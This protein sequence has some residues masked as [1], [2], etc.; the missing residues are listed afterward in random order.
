MI[1][2]YNEIK[3]KNKTLLNS[4][5]IGVE[6]T[7]VYIIRGKN[8]TGKSLLINYLY[9]KLIIRKEKAVFID[10]TND[11]ILENEGVLQNIALIDNVDELKKIESKLQELNMSYL[12]EHTSKELS[13]GEK[14]LICLLRGLLAEADYYFIDEPTNDLDYEITSKIADLIDEIGKKALVLLVTHDDRMDNY[15]NGIYTIK[16]KHLVNENN[17]VST[18]K[19]IIND[20]KEDSNQR[21]S[22]IKER[23]LLKQFSFKYIT[24]LLCIICLLAALDSGISIRDAYEQQIDMMK[25]RQIDIFIP[26]SKFGNEIIEGALPIAYASF[27]RGDAS[28]SEFTNEMRKFYNRSEQEQINFT[29]DLEST[30]N[31][32][33]YKLEY[34]DVF[35]QESFLVLEDYLR[36][37][38]KSPEDIFVDT[39]QYFEQV[40]IENREGL[41]KVDFNIEKFEENALYYENNMT[42]SSKPY[43]LIFCSVIL[44]EGYSINKF[45]D[46]SNFK[47]LKNG[48]FYIRSNETISI[49]NAAKILESKKESIIYFFVT[50]FVCL[51]IELI[52]LFLYLK[53]NRLKI[54]IFRNMSYLPCKIS[55]NVISKMKDGTIR[56]VFCI[57]LL[58]LCILQTDD[59]NQLKNMGYSLIYVLYFIY[60]FIS[61]IIIRAFSKKYIEKTADWRYR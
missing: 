38:S 16:G 39:T 58:F 6:D 7:G 15:A 46:D 18:I 47:S 61:F 24:V 49:V 27:A 17:K 48:N 53:T 30:K 51:S 31:Y 43:E 52:Y 4:G 33:V 60:Q 19:N 3:V 23:F 5:Q 44:N 12:L 55:Y 45:F 35:S 41:S 36:D 20:T 40:N 34:Y 37:Y 8:G 54:R 28:L 25:E 21:S 13:G 2:E 10:Q 42:S 14:R 1:F 11:R 22:K 29:L 50:S 26:V 9:Q 57:L 56:F 32:H 59:L